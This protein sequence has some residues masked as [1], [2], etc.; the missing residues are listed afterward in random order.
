MNPAGKN[1]NT[2]PVSQDIQLCNLQLGPLIAKG[3][4]SA[5]YSARLCPEESGM[6]LQLVIKQGLPSMRRNLS[7]LQTKCNLLNWRC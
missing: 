6:N 5:V 3:S 7:K 4:N 2:E 1:E